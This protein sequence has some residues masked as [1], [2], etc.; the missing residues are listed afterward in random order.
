MG[1]ESIRRVP[2]HRAP[3][4]ALV[5]RLQNLGGRPSHWHRG[6]HIGKYRIRIRG[7]HTAHYR[8]PPVRKHGERGAAG[9]DGAELRTAGRRARNVLVPGRVGVDLHRTPGAVQPSSRGTGRKD[10]VGSSTA[11]S[12]KAPTIGGFGPAPAR[13]IVTSLQRPNLHLVPPR[14]RR[15]RH[16]PHRR[17]RER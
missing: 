15:A 11:H 2:H 14:R 6:F 5:L 9:S 13:L 16:P 10:D 17:P 4:P 8:G 12:L 3:D 7:H 1:Q